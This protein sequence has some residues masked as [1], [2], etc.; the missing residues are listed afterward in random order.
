[1]A[2]LAQSLPVSRNQSS[3]SAPVIFLGRL[4]FVLIFVMSGFAHFAKQTIAFAASQGVP[5]ASVLVP[6][7]GVIALL[8]GLSILLGYRAKLGAWLIVIFL[9]GV[10]PLHKFWG[11]SDPMMQ[12]I[13]MAM[14][15]KNLAMIG[16]AL[17]ITQFSSG[18]WSLDA[19]K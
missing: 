8:G 3:V 16:G 11:M 19:R 9:V 6:L 17:L 7:S 5:M 2:T 10:T 18:P 12:Q 4:L 14:F 13:Q 1:M 15:M